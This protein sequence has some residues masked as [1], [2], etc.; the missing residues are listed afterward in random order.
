MS[1]SGS[2]PSLLFRNAPRGLDRKQI[3]GF[4]KKL[5]SAVSPGRAFTVLITNDK[6]LQRL[7][8][9]FLGKD[10]ATDVLSFPFEGPG[11]ELGEIA[12]SAQLA[13]IQSKEFSHTV[14]Q[15]ISI[16]MLHGV[17]HLQGMDHQA[18][19][20]K[21]R[22]AETKWRLELGLPQGLIERTKR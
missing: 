2:K 4:A 20:G 22:R 16:L 13:R 12:I 1:S 15:E 11:M 18:D 3:R 17:L 8:A 21:M 19:R 6:E 5:C 9:A 10:Y 7:N 14:E